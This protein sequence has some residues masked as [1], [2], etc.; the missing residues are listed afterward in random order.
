MI[1]IPPTPKFAYFVTMMHMDPFTHGSYQEEYNNT[2]DLRTC[3]NSF[4]PR[5]MKRTLKLTTISK[6]GYNL[7]YKLGKVVCTERR[8]N[9][10]YQRGSY[11]GICNAF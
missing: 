11:L 1:S 4:N 9:A 8:R 3:F 10:I 7:L 5:F 2:H 6:M